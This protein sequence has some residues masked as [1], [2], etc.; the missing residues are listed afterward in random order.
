MPVYLTRR[1]F[2][3][4]FGALAAGRASASA[5]QGTAA[6]VVVIGGGFGGATAANATRELDSSIAVTMID[7]ERSFVT[8]PFSNDV[9]IGR[10]DLQSITH[11]FRALADKHGV[12]VVHDTATAVDTDRRQVRLAG[13]G[14][15]DYDRL[16]V[17]PG[18]DFRWNALPGYDEAAS[19]R[20]PHAWKGGAQT[21]L[22]RRQL[23]SMDDGGTFIIVAPAN[24]YRCPP[25][26]YER[27]SLVAS[28]FKQRKPRSK[29][30]ILD[31]KDQFPAQPHFQSAWKARYGEMIEWVALSQDGKVS[32]VIPGEMA[33]V[34]EFGERHEGAVIN[35]VPPQ[36]AGRIARDAG[37]A[38]QTGWC[39]VDPLT[40]ES[41]LRKNVHVIGD[42]TLAG[43][44][45][46][47][48]HA[49]HSQAKVAAAAIVA[50]LRGRPAPAPA[51]T[52]VCYSFVA[53]ET[54]LAISDRFEPGAEGIMAVAGAGVITAPDAAAAR[55]ADAW[56]R[57]MTAEIW[58]S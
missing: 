32:E 11:E 6:R 33:V 46:K 43:A 39:P 37:L 2:G 56:Y 22:L 23:E 45:P 58:G 48:G 55:D 36:A 14:L 41:T 29:I 18:I 49:A 54:A 27:A 28:Y 51:Y 57:S 9:L 40:L 50:A 1:E 44:M 24:P 34:S 4:G 12:K 5:A 53:P 10:R 7:A 21:A 38:N 3:F 17:S 30:L 13:G 47:G 35:V 25:A 19:E 31:A 52:N 15:L 42:A 16:V 26:I 20:M 8:C